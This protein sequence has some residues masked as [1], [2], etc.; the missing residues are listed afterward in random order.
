MRI[1]ISYTMYRL[2]YI[3]DTV[4]TLYSGQ[5]NHDAVGHLVKCRVIDEYVYLW[6][7]ISQKEFHCRLLE[8]IYT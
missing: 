6:W 5:K 3:P 2:I 4:V 7:T 1:I 8:E